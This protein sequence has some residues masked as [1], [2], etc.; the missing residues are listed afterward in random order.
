ME[1]CVLTVFSYDFYGPT[2]WLQIPFHILRLWRQL[3]ALLSNLSRPLG[4]DLPEVREDKVQ[5]ILTPS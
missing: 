3:C 5:T 2:P 1:I 4:L